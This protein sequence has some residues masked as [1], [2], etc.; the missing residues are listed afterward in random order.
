MKT[1]EELLTAMRQHTYTT[2]QELADQIGESRPNLSKLISQYGLNQEFEDNKKKASAMS[3]KWE[4]YFAKMREKGAVEWEEFLAQGGEIDPPRINR[5]T[6]IALN[7]G[8]RPEVREKIRFWAA[9]KANYN[10]LTEDEQTQIS[11]A[12]QKTT[13]I[14]LPRPKDK[15][16]KKIDL[17]G[18][19]E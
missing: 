11:L 2:Q 18:I 5:T 9:A 17:G 12:L 19:T 16:K 1:K 10:D 14:I 3:E 13:I 4:R 15:E 7:S 6:Y 8:I